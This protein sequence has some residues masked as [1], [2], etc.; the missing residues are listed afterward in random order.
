MET[1]IE[2]TDGIYV[3]KSQFKRGE[4]AQQHRHT[5]AH[6]S[7]VASGFFCV[8]AEGEDSR[9]LGPGDTLVMPAGVA[10]GVL[11]RTD[12]TWLCIHR[13]DIVDVDAVDASLID[14][15]DA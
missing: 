7:A 11:A 8:T 14:N 15:P 10:H 5:F 6:V 2:L 3:K 12:G 13:T 9:E 1:E 4:H